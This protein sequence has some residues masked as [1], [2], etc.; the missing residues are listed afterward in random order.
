MT[1]A[2]TSAPREPYQLDRTKNGNEGGSACRRES[3]RAGRRG[4]GATPATQLGLTHASPTE[5]DPTSRGEEVLWSVVR[6]WA[7]PVA[8]GRGGCPEPR[9]HPPQWALTGAAA[10]MVDA[11]PRPVALSA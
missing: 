8:E 4:I 11:A 2:R 5:M 3:E 7:N 1:R 9:H 6:K 10:E